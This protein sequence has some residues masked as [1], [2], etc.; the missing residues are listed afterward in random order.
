MIL[1]GDQIIKTLQEK[2]TFPKVTVKDFYAV[3]KVTPPMVTV[4]ELPGEG[5][6][7]PDGQ[8]K[9]VR[10]SFQFEVYCKQQTINGTSMTAIAAAKALML[11]LDK[12]LNQTFGLTQVGD[13][14]FSPYA[15]DQNIM[16]GVARYR[17]DIDTRTEIIY[18]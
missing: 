12:I 8:P 11:E 4:N 13:V 6:L 10:N 9:I 7:F 2:L 15:S 1:I 14:P 18:R 5:V 17:G 16:R 3:S